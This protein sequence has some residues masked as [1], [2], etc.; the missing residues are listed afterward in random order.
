MM[1]LETVTDIR[2]IALEHHV[3]TLNHQTDYAERVT[4]MAAI[5]CECGAKLRSSA[6]TQ[7]DSDR[8]VFKSHALHVGQAVATY[9]AE[10]EAG[11]V[12]L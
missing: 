8:R 12:T 11:E 2:Q 3:F 10:C 4:F 6:K 1:Q 9:L 7:G 5:T